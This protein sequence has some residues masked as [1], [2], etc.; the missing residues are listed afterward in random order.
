MISIECGRSRTA[1]YLPIFA[2]LEVLEMSVV[3]LEMEELLDQ[4][5]T[6]GK[7]NLPDDHSCIPKF[8]N[9]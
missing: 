4:S 1:H 6:N 2:W 5:E 3:H 7:K 8:V 9:Q